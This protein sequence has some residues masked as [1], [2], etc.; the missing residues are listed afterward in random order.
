[1]NKPDIELLHGILDQFGEETVQLALKELKDQKIAFCQK[2][3]HDFPDPGEELCDGVD[4]VMPL[5][6]QPA[7]ERLIL[8][9]D[10][11]LPV[12]FLEEGAKVQKAVARI[13]TRTQFGTGFMVSKSLF[14]T[15][16]H[17]IPDVSTANNTR[18]QFN[19]QLDHYGNA[20]TL[21]E[22]TLDTNVFRT[23][24]ALDYTLVRVRPKQVTFGLSPFE[25]ESAPHE[26]FALDVFPQLMPTI[27]RWPIPVWPSKNAGEVYGHIPLR[28]H[29][30]SLGQ[31]VSIIQHPDGRRKEAAV[32]DNKVSQIFANYFRYTT[33]TEPGS[34]GSPV[35]NNAW[36]LVGLHHAGGAQDQNG[37]WL[38][39]QGVRIDKIIADLQSHF[40]GSINGNAIIREL[41]I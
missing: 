20:L 40:A 10:N 22:F 28:R 35:F 9:E 11:L 1:M 14:L 27:R 38:S 19:Y 31:R 18:I 39:N 6:D 12:H 21:D 13:R 25:G 15:N 26:I 34:S 33:D 36:D 17:V 4:G 7:L 8:P 23:N 41:G 16:N 29:G 32:H 3:I 2:T 37:R 24:R 5:E 30:F